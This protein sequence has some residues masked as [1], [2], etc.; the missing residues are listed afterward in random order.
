MGIQV[1]VVLLDQEAAALD[2]IAEL[3][4]RLAFDSGSDVADLLHAP[5]IDLSPLFKPADRRFIVSGLVLRATERHPGIDTLAEACA[6]KLGCRALALSLSEAY[7]SGA[8]QLWG[9][10]GPISGLVIDLELSSG[11]NSILI[12]HDAAEFGVLALFRT[13]I[14]CRAGFW[15]RLLDLLEAGTDLRLVEGG[16]PLS[17][18]RRLRE[19]EGVGWAWH[20]WPM[21]FPIGAAV[22]RR[23]AQAYEHEQRRL[24]AVLAE[25]GLAA[26]Q[27]ASREAIR[28]VFGVEP[29]RLFALWSD[30]NFGVWHVVR[31]GS[32]VRHALELEASLEEPRRSTA[33]SY[34]WLPFGHRYLHLELDESRGVII[35]TLALDL[36]APGGADFS[37]CLVSTCVHERYD[38]V[39]AWLET[40]RRLVEPCAILRPAYERDPN[41]VN[42]TLRPGFDA[43]AWAQ[44]I[45]AKA[46]VGEDPRLLEKALVRFWADPHSTHS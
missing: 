22:A 2:P 30:P 45:W 15:D 4:R 29:D 11:G 6:R 31:M 40:E 23:A 37:V 8:F 16:R 9:P 27:P 13:R 35:A 43:R 38:S 19:D 25:H 14:E 3:A 24:E 18:A 46:G 44:P 33:H 5:S 12:P 42:R 41:L 20:S 21:T 17:P 10:D 28:R 32:L 34:R 1:G 36:D 39:E 7:G 26:E